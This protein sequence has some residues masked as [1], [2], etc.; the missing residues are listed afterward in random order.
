LVAVAVAL[1]L[2][3]LLGL[4][5][6]QRQRALSDAKDDLSAQQAENADLQR[7]VDALNEAQQNQ[8]T[9]DTLTVQF[10]TILENDVS[11]AVQLQEIARTI[12]DDTWLTSYQGTVTTGAATPA[13]AGVPATTPVAT[14]GALTGTVSFSAT[15]LDFP[16][17]ASWLTRV[18]EIPSYSNVWV[19]TAT[20]TEIGG[21][22]VVDFTSNAALTAEAQ[23]DRKNRFDD[24][25]AGG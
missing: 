13:A 23:S 12:P 4:L 15:G 19:P 2:L 10:T 5:T 17:I 3:L 21:R 1:G 9:I 18:G 22:T 14:P 25:A 7:Q 8:A 16:A 11:W 24:G 20:S 6:F